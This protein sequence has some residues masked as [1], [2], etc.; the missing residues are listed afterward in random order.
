M[1]GHY[2]SG[3]RVIGRN[4]NRKMFE[5]YSKVARSPLTRMH[6]VRMQTG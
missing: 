2:V 5:K 4:I 6:K 3:G 1:A